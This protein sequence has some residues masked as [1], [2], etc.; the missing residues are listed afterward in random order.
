MR[1]LVA[2]RRGCTGIVTVSFLPAARRK[3]GGR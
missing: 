3:G 1:V 2:G